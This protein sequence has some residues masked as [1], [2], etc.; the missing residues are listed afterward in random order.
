MSQYRIELSVRDVATGLSINAVSSAPLT[1]EQLNS[2]DIFKTINNLS[3]TLIGHARIR[4]SERTRLT[5]YP[6][7]DKDSSYNLRH[8]ADLLDSGKFVCS[9]IKRTRGAGTKDDQQ[10]IWIL[11]DPKKS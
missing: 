4:G 7:G 10:E 6:P 11:L 2:D 1:D 5:A 9:V 8:F 3:L